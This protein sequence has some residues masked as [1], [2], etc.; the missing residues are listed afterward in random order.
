MRALVQRVTEASVAIQSVRHSG[1]GPG[2]LIFLGVR[3][4]DDRSAASY[5]AERCASLRMFEDAEGKM[6]RSV[7][8]TGGAALVVSQFTLYG[9]TRKGNRP[10]FADAAGPA[11]AQELYEE[12]VRELRARI[13]DSN[14]ATGVFRAAMQVQ[15]VNDGPVTL[16]IETKEPTPLTKGT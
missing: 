9:D 10:G 6:N 3:A 15:L 12:F 1:I 5:L 7:L 14:V 13:G 2:I 4:G 16:M 11:E 8:D